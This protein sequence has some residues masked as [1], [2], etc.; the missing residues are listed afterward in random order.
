MKLLPLILTGV[1]SFSMAAEALQS[2]S[3][4]S[5][6][7]PGNCVAVVN[8]KGRFQDPQTWAPALEL[9]SCQ[10]INQDRTQRWFISDSKQIQ[11]AYDHNL[12]LTKAAASNPSLSEC[13]TGKSSQIFELNARRSYYLIES[14]A[15]GCL[16]A[17]I[18]DAGAT[19]KVESSLCSKIFSRNHW[20]VE[21]KEWL[22]ESE[23]FLLGQVDIRT[24]DIYYTNPA[25]GSRLNLSNTRQLVKALY[26]T[27]ALNV[28][29]IHAELDLEDSD[30]LGDGF[31]TLNPY[32]PKYTGND[33]VLPK[34]RS[35]MVDGLEVFN[36][37]GYNDTK[38]A[39]KI[40]DN[41]QIQWHQ[42]EVISR[43]FSDVTN[44]GEKSLEVCAVKFEAG[45]TTAYSLKTFPNL[46]Q[47]QLEGYTVTHQ[48]QCGTCSTLKDLAVYIGVPNQTEPVRLCTKRSKGDWS[49]LDEV[50]QCIQESVGFS[51]Q[52]AESWAYNGLNS[53]DN[54]QSICMDTYSGF[55]D[56]VIKEEFNAC[57]PEVETTDPVLRAELEFN[58]CPLAN[59]TNGKLNACLWAD[60]RVSGPG[61][62]YTAAR[63]RRG[64]GLPSAIPR[65]NDTLFFQADHTQY[66]R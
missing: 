59:E 2:I 47:A 36:P 27:Q 46:E 65:P 66:F 8:D 60:E 18:V 39:Y 43:W 28:E 53:A 56:M 57:P 51:E 16:A 29:Q 17:G 7:Y 5:K 42:Q 52:C 63:T 35:V 44:G 9:T 21:N 40:G 41:G 62:K 50:K 54:N 3:I 11:W 33:I 24:A 31:S 58:G 26:T 37:E 12:C 49:K 14:Q 15:G 4:E 55:L 34:P 32:F 64:S 38:E 23:P 1:S 30:K 19:N 20:Y 45:S 48:Y 6:K 22:D 10:E 13:K 61:F 25:T